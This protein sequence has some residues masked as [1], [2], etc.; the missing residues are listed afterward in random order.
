LKKQ[1]GK[2]WKIKSSSKGGRKGWKQ[3]NHGGKKVRYLKPY[4]GKGEGGAKRDKA[5]EP[6]SGGRRKGKTNDRE[7]KGRGEDERKP[8]KAPGCAKERFKEPRACRQNREEG[9]VGSQ[10]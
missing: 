1:K 6:R 4:K 7:T 9:L 10:E 3:E 8:K 2:A 5:T